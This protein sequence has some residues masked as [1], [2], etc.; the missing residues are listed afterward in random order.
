[1]MLGYF[2]PLT[3]SANLF[4]IQKDVG[5]A[6]RTF[7]TSCPAIRFT[8]DEIHSFKDSAAIVGP[9]DLIISV[10]TSLA[11]L[12]DALGKPVYVLLPWIPEWRWLLDRDGSPWYPTAKVFRQPSQ[13]DWGSAI[14]AA[15]QAIA[16]RK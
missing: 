13:N 4:L 14:H 11:H 9:M 3:R 15:S 16:S 10:D 2:E 6:D 8:D 1:M 7:L 12:A 5:A